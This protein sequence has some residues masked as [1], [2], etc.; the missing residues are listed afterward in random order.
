VW[1][2]VEDVRVVSRWWKVSGE[3]VDSDKTVEKIKTHTHNQIEG[4]GHNN[5]HWRQCKYTDTLLLTL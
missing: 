5:H 3:K 1:G 4:T 2:W